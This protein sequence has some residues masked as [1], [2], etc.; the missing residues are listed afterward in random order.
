MI[1]AYRLVRVTVSSKA[2]DV[3]TF[4]S[5]P[6]KVGPVCNY[7]LVPQKPTAPETLLMRKAAASQRRHTNAGIFG[8]RST[9]R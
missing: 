5:T 9:T 4:L 1:P 6:Q 2:I 7:Y 8:S 3:K